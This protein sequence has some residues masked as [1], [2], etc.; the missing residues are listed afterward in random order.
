MKIPRVFHQI[1]LGDQ[2]M[3]SRFVAWAAA[4]RTLHPAWDYCL[5]RSDEVIDILSSGGAS[6]VSAHPGLLRDACT[7]TQRANIW[8]F[9]LLKAFGGVY[10]DTDMEPFKNI[11]PLIDD[12]EAF[13]G[14][15]MPHVNR[16][17]VS[18][19]GAVPGHP[20]MVQAVAQLTECNPKVLG[21]TGSKYLT[22]ITQDHPEV[23]VF[24]SGEFY[25]GQA[26]L[27]YAFHHHSNRWF[28]SFRAIE[29]E[30]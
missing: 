23:T 8:R 28:P 14:M 5:W 17:G 11:E 26:P 6:L 18:V 27:A 21:S 3:H 30:K 4:W 9:E 13:A 16:V 7:Y 19:F 15:V 10:L 2:P 12:A 25:R 22:K 1:W 20:W 24:N 29:P